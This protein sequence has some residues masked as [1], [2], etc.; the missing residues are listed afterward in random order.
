MGDAGVVAGV[1]GPELC[2]LAVVVVGHCSRAVITGAGEIP[3][4]EH[5]QTRHEQR[6]HQHAGVVQ[7]PDKL[8]R[9]GCQVHAQPEVAAHHVPRTVAPHDPELLRRLPNPV[10]QF[11]R[12]AEDRADLWCGVTARR[13]VGGAQ[14]VKKLQ[15]L[16]I[17]FWRLW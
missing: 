5:R 13:D 4:V 11:A 3:T 6:F 17:A 15:L 14:R 12:P 10:S 9:F 2:A 1:G 7:R 16:G 8:H